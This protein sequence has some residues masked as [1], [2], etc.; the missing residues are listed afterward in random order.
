[1]VLGGVHVCVL[2]GH[3]LC[4]VVAQCVC[5]QARMCNDCK[6]PGGG[7]VLHFFILAF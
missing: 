4:G 2:P 5:V 1:M 3:V 6:G 7:G